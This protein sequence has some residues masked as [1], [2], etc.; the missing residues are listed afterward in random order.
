MYLKCSCIMKWFLMAISSVATWCYLRRVAL[1]MKVE[2][3]TNLCTGYRS[4]PGQMISVSLPR[5]PLLQLPTLLLLML[6]S[7]S[8]HTGHLS[9]LLAPEA[10][11]KNWFQHLSPKV[12]NDPPL[13]QD[14]FQGYGSF[15]LLSY[16]NTKGL[17]FF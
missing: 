2:A 8:L 9:C 6:S 7:F 5:V 15:S 17:L 4:T 3:G 12:L 11:P 16:E 10:H 1:C 14:P 13:P